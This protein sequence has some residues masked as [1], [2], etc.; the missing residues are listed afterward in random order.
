MMACISMFDM[1]FTKSCATMQTDTKIQKYNSEKN[2]YYG[3]IYYI[4]Y[5]LKY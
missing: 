2:I 4:L 1:I 3:F 5:I